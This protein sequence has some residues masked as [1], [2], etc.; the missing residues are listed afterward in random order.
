MAIAKGDQ[1]EPIRVLVADSS[2][3][4]SELMCNALRRQA[5]FLVVSCKALQSEAREAARVFE[6]D[7]I[8]LGE[9]NQLPACAYDIIRDL[10]SI[11]S[12][13]A[14]VLVV[15]S[16]DR[17]L[18]VN[19]LRAGAR[20]IFCEA[21]QTFKALCKCIHAVH[22]GQIWTNTEQ[23][24]YVIEAL[25]DSPPIKITDAKGE[26]LLTTRENQVVSLVAEGLGNRAVAKRL[27]IT[28]NTVKKSLLR[29]FDK[30]GIS[31]RVELVLYAMS[32]RQTRHANAPVPHPHATNA[33]QQR[34]LENKV[35]IASARLAEIPVLAATGAA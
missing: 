19:A 16:Y 4:K 22:E 21:T 23:M 7:V 28:E 30:L 9:A 31:N 5:G 2:Q 10:K 29:I 11:P 17:E 12:Q 34:H 24:E 18:V 6:P 25:A 20:G 33:A 14:I 26:T 27:S 15:D 35:E 8:L 13:A 32:S 1:A 3:T